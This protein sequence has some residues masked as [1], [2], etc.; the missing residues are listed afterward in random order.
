MLKWD[1]YNERKFLRIHSPLLESESQIIAGFGGKEFGT[2]EDG[3]SFG[4]K[5]IH[6]DII[7]TGEEYLGATDK[8]FEGDGWSLSR[9][10]HEGSSS[11]FFIRTAD[12]LPVIIISESRI[13]LIHAGWRGLRAGILERALDTFQGEAQLL[14]VCIGPAADP[15]HYEVGQEFAEYFDK[16]TLAPKEEGK[17]LFN[18]YKAAEFSLRKGGYSEEIHL[19]PVN[20]ISD[21]RFFSYRKEPSSDGRNLS[22]IAFSTLKKE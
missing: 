22:F 8:V 3:A 10:R 1:L 20:T 17:Y 4:L 19:P 18:L 12:C 6:S 14:E 11:L 16:E 2:L 9:K 21:E 5:Q 15:M 13:A 7:I